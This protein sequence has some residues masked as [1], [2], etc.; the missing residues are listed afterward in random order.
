M[1]EVVESTL[2]YSPVGTRSYVVRLRCD[3]GNTVTFEDFDSRTIEESWAKAYRRVECDCGGHDR[4]IL[5]QLRDDEEERKAD[6]RR[7]E[8]RACTAIMGN[9]L[10]IANLQR[11]GY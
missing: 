2:K 9:I 1:M 6:D 8:D 4:R 10:D 3:C 7:H 5:D 11:G